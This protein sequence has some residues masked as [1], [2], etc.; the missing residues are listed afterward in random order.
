[1]SYFN[2]L[3]EK[4]YPQFLV[5][6]S[7][8]YVFGFL[9][10]PASAGKK[11]KKQNHEGSFSQ[12]QL[13]TDKTILNIGNIT[14]WV[15]ADGR[16]G[17]A[18]SGDAVTIFPRGT[19]PVVFQD[20]IIWGGQV[21]DGIEPIIRVGGNTYN[22]GTQP[23]SIISPGVPE[24]PADRQNIKR[25]WRI[26]REP[27]PEHWEYEL[28]NA[29]AEFFNI[30][31]NEV[32]EEHVFQVRDIYKQDWLDWPADKGAPFYDA[33]G[34]GKYNPAFDHNGWPKLAPRPG[35]E[36]Y[37][38]IHADEPGLAN[39][40]QVIWY[41]SNDLDTSAVAEL[42]GSPPIGLE[43][44]TTLWGYGYNNLRDV[45][46][47]RVRLV[48][49][50]TE[51]TPTGASIDSMYV[52]QWADM[53]IGT[54][55]DDLAGCDPY[56][57]L[58][59]S[60]NSVTNDAAFQKFDLT[61]PAAGYD[62]LA[63]PFVPH[64]SSEAIVDLKKRSGFSNLPMTS[65]VVDE[66]TGNTATYDK[67]LQYF[68]VL[69]GFSAR[70][71]NTLNSTQIIDP[72]TNLPTQFA[73]NG[74]PITGNGWLDNDARDVEIFQASGPFYLGLGDFNEM[75]IAFVAG[76]SSDRL[77]SV[78]MMKHIARTAQQV[79][80]N[81]FEM[82]TYP[83]PP[84]VIVT[85]LDGQII[86]KWSQTTE[87]RE[88][89]EQ[90]G[91]AGFQ[92]EG[93]NVYQF[94]EAKGYGFYGEHE[95]L[96]TFDLVNEIT[97]IEQDEFDWQSATLVSKVV[98]IASNSGIERSLIIDEDKV[99][100]YRQ[101][102][103]NGHE[104]HFGVTAYSVNSYP[105]AIRKYL[106]SSIAKVAVIPQSLSPGMRLANSS[107]DTL[108]ATHTQGNS[109]GSVIPIV[110]DPTQL[111]GDEYKITFSENRNKSVWNLH[112]LRNNS[113]VLSGMTNQSGDSDYLIMQ[114]VKVVVTGPQL[115][116]ADWRDEG[117]RWIGGHKEADGELMFDS[118][119]LGANFSGSS[120][121]PSRFRDVQMAWFEKQGNSDLNGN[122]AYDVG[123]PYQLQAGDGH[124]KAF[125]YS[126]EG[127]GNFLGFFDVPFS[128][129]DAESNP[130]RQL[131]VLIHDYDGNLQWDLHKQ[132]AATDSDFVDINNGD[133][134]FNYVFILDTDYDD[135]GQAYDPTQGGVDAF[136]DIFQAG[137]PVQW[138]GW[139]G[140]LESQEPLESTFTLDLI[141]PKVNTPQDEFVFT[142]IA[143]SF[144]EDVAK[145][146]VLS[147][148]NV[149][150]N[151]YY[152][153]FRTGSGPGNRT[154][155]FSHLSPVATVRIFSLA[156]ALVRTFK[157]DDNSQFLHWDLLNEYER[158]VGSG[159]Y[160]AHI[161]M[162]EL[163][164]SKI[165]KLAL[166]H[167]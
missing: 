167:E 105:Q 30:E 83:P 48:Y 163:G 159:I 123:E 72:T 94:K 25:V 44:Q 166:V 4:K 63:G 119:Y 38:S 154:V 109:D 71:T 140:Q 64:A 93:Y 142:T 114:G 84:S 32:T 19:A 46:F 133:F 115:T 58:G 69:R 137:Q 16:S 162:T 73:Y 149:F 104:Y 61:S 117:L 98:Q 148:A 138:L 112:N 121:P 95:K 10:L 36:F 54:R 136:A 116:G 56:L 51:S 87:E 156:G 3:L 101:P 165:L 50:G 145:Q 22:E 13:T 21:R 108:Q 160:I 102:L 161:E 34:D 120:L 130:P 75:N 79:F 146:D 66:I 99:H 47:K 57:D 41:V 150:P 91:N 85:E 2:F 158:L 52:A 9:V 86:L 89:I 90:W 59:Y 5:I 68:N 20:G 122:G 74:D 55:K 15:Y 76:I 14:M 11:D 157:K 39:A 24:D 60:Y 118:V 125:F 100:G 88:L 26:R 80:D 28:R 18:P 110:V 35:E 126:K 40:D 82:P 7:V 155:T 65:F 164:V 53:E 139:W 62:I 147:L 8:I 135:T 96:A 134:R 27:I 103:R 6:V 42:S 153:L 152:G 132:Y 92:F 33:D 124:Q 144:D 17:I 37:P 128:V 113:T 67:T 143:P 49:K 111:T 127:T 97:T 151:P 77:R 78:A 43:V 107:G 141:A 81:L 23:G 12:T 45:V 131:N 106:Q 1:M 70:P 31:P 29:A 129:F